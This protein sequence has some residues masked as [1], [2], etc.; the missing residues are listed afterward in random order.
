MHADFSKET[1][2]DF[3]A[4]DERDRLEWA[5]CPMVAS[6]CQMEIGKIVECCYCTTLASI[7][8]SIFW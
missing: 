5:A 2:L 7:L 3:I 8:E 1:R 6:A 4:K